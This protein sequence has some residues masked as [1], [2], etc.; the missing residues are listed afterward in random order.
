VTALGDLLDPAARQRLKRLAEP[1]IQDLATAARQAAADSAGPGRTA[2]SIV[3]MAL[4]CS[5][6]SAETA[7]GII[8]AIVR[9]DRVRHLA[10][11]CLTTICRDDD[12]ETA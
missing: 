12:L 11:A 5:G 8:N 9:D 3:A 7:S 2:W 1:D 10:Q 4:D 6:G